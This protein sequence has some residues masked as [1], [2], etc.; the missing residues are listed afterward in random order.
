MDI[1]RKFGIH[2]L[3]AIGLVA[4]DFVLFGA[5][6]TG[7]GWILSCLV[8]TALMLPSILIQHFAYKDNWGTAIAKG[9]IVG[10]LTAIPTPLPAVITGTG[11]IMGLL[12]MLKSGAWSKDAAAI[13]DDVQAADNHQ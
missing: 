2:P 6:A 8:A 13:K 10:V 5:D 1:M 4:V 9:I 3:V 7:V 12:G 11:G